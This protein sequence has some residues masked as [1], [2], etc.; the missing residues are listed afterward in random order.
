ML[1]FQFEILKML[2]LE[3]RH[4]VEL[5]LKLNSSELPTMVIIEEFQDYDVDMDKV[6]TIRKKFELK[7]I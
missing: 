7:E 6:N 1:D 3:G 5:T 2:G 4:I